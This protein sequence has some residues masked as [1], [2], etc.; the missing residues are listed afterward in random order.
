MRVKIFYCFSLFSA[1]SL[2]CPA[3]L[4]TQHE[5]QSFQAPVL[6]GVISSDEYGPGNSY[7]FS[8]GGSGFGGQFGNA[9]MYMKASVANLYIAFE[10]LGVPTDA[11]QYLIY[12]NTRSGGFQ[13]N[14]TDM[15]DASDAGRSNVSRMSR[16]GA[17][18]VT[19]HDGATTASPDFALLL[20]NRSESDGGFA[21]LLELAPAGQQ[22]N[23]L[24]MQRSALGAS[25]IEFAIPLST[26]GLSPGDSVD[27]AAFNISATGFL[28]NEGIPATGLGSNPGFADGQSNEFADFHRFTTFSAGPQVGLT[29]RVPNVTLA[30]PEEL[31][32][33]ASQ[34]YQV[35]DAF[36]G[37]AFNLPM[38]IRVPPGE[39]NRLFVS[40]R[41]GQIVV[42][43]NL[44]TLGTSTFFDLSSVIAT[45]GEGGLISFAFHPDYANNGYFYVY[46]SLMT[47]T[48]LGNGFHLRLS[49][50]Q[51]SASDPN[52][53]DSATEQ[54]LFTQYHRRRNHNGGDLH[55][56]PD[57]YL[58]VSLGDEGG[59]NDPYDNG[60]RID[61]GFFSS[62]MRIDVD[63]KPGSIA[64]N[65]HP[66]IAGST[67]NY[68]VPADNPFIGATE[69]NGE[70]VDPDEVRTE[71]YAIG[72]RNPFRFT[73]DAANGDLLLADVGQGAREEI[74]L[75]TAGGNYGWKWR[76]GLIP[77]PGIGTPPS[78]FT[79]WI[80]PLIEYTHGSATNQGRSVTGGV[81]YYGDAFPELL[82]HYIFGDYVSGHVWSMTHDGTNATSFNWLGTTPNIVSFGEDPRNGD[83]L[84]AG[85]TQGPLRRLVRAAGDPNDLPQTLSATGA[86]YDL[87]NLVPFAG[88]VA[89]D[90][91]V[92][93]WSDNSLK[94]RWFSVPDP[95]DVIQFAPEGPWTFPDGTVWI[96][97]FDLELIKGDP[98]SAQRLETRLLVKNNSGAGG[99]GVTYRWGSSTDDAVLVPAGG[100]NESF[101]VQDGGVIYT[102]VWRYPS[103]NECL[104]CH[105][106]DAGF[107][108][109]FNT[110]Q[111]NRDFSFAGVV[112]NQLCA[113]SEVGYLDTDVKDTIHTLRALAHPTNTLYSLEYRA[114]SYIHANCASC[115]FP[116]GPFLGNFD[117]RIESA[118]SQTD[119]LNGVLANEQGNPD[120][121]TIVPGDPALSMIH[122]RI[123]SDGGDRMPPVGSNV[124]DT[125]GVALV[126]DWINELVGYQS[127][128]DW[129]LVHFESTTDPDAQPGADPDGDGADNWT[130]YLTGT[131]P[132]D[133]SDVWAIDIALHDDVP[134]VEF[135]RVANT[136]F[137]VQA[138]TNLLDASSWS[139]LNVPGNRPLI[140]GMTSLVG[141]EDPT[142][143]NLMNRFYR[144]RIY[145]P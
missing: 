1:L 29:E 8:G 56:G 19:F 41:A 47:S 91:N 54:V 48:S 81:V 127:F 3:A 21:A 67:T 30:M 106:P 101:V 87:E 4:I 25:V 23:L 120:N 135:L 119:L 85:L 139:P 69:F 34:S 138:T 123:A 24:T 121:R 131:D 98:S 16:D 126:V 97:H 64:P 145:E 129:Q 82:G 99:Y 75:I 50:F 117:A 33:E 42:V 113:F 53:T 110:E 84:I 39:T 140:S 93:F 32:P 43:T 142:A 88:I 18:S 9:T 49:R 122:T 144:V 61:G 86:F 58:Y 44:A 124:I 133:P 40:E 74:N 63:M 112:T 2:S 31:P 141:V 134:S 66:A 62:V 13:P 100:L 28:S 14:G 70:S 137:E 79:N 68:A 128:E 27:F 90:L 36:G 20:N 96:K 71:I 59:G 143:T 76:E 92:P 102:Q 114:R 17:D 38:S 94:K 12:F 77:T 104:L 78:G 46:Y 37:L 10:N 83:V 45:D 132:N 51:V 60:Q 26:L 11:N 111:L 95:S 55:F 109:G 115:H 73:F 22:H 130:E 6:D 103:R 107:A 72:L 80:D 57:G 105:Q 52:W 108:L 15:D 118:L 125:D 116:D 7:S 5:D 65:P 136:G 35:E 89:Y